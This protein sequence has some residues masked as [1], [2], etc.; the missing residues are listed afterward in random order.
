[1]TGTA[2]SV[3]H[4]RHSL[5][6]ALHALEVEAAL[7]DWLGADRGKDQRH[8]IEE[9][10]PLADHA[11]AVGERLHVGV[12]VLGRPGLEHQAHRATDALV[13]ELL[14]GGPHGRRISGI[15]IAN[16]VSIARVKPGVGV[17]TIS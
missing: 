15:C 16:H 2:V 5:R 1:M 14:D 3:Q 7:V 9:L 11:G 8:P 4:S 12:A 10:L 13:P 6:G 17:S